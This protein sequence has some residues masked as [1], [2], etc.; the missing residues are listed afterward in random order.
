VSDRTFRRWRAREIGQLPN[1][2]IYRLGSLVGGLDG[3]LRAQPAPPGGAPFQGKRSGVQDL[4]KP[5]QSRPVINTHCIE[6]GAFL[7]PQVLVMKTMAALS[8]M[9]AMLSLF[10]KPRGRTDKRVPLP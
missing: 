3:G 2:T 9:I 7:K 4:R 5:G 10:L 1:D 6:L 8:R